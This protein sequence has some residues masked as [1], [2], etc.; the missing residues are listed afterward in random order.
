VWCLALLGDTSVT[1]LLCLV[2][3]VAPVMAFA[4]ISQSRFQKSFVNTYQSKFIT[5]ATKTLTSM[6][7]ELTVN[8]TWDQGRR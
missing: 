4:R 6:T 2:L 8:S 1:W 5:S 3:H 7:A